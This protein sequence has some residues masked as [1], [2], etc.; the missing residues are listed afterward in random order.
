MLS[1]DEPQDLV[2]DI[3]AD[4][5]ERTVSTH[6]EAKFSE[7]ICAFSNDLP[8]HGLPGYLLIGVHD[9]GRPSGLKVTD[10][11]LKDLGGLRANGK[12]LPPPTMSVFRGTLQG[13]RHEVVVVE[14]RP[15][16]MPP[17]RYDGRVWIRVG[18]R[19]AVATEAEERLLS[20]RRASSLARTFDA[21]PCR[22]SALAD[23]SVDLF[24]LTYL[25]NAPSQGT[26]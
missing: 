24:K 18:P 7:A 25:P 26:S 22:G 21:R 17:V 23:L 10:K 12:I 20:E 16:D 2:D 3:E 8:G 1:E 19:K 14:V 11:L 15:S 4:R 5:V 13:G 9:D 6:D